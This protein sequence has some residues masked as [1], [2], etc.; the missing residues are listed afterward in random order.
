MESK[1]NTLT[2]WTEAYRCRPT[3]DKSGFETFCLY[4][5]VS[6]GSGDTPEEAK[7]DFLE[8]IRLRIQ[9]L[10]NM[11]QFCAERDPRQVK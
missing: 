11:L 3:A 10:T 6:A 1:G 7:Q 8:N 2:S 9:E 5:E 4:E